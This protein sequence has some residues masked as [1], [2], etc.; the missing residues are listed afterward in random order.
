MSGRLVVIGSLMMDLVV[1]TPR[2]PQNGESIIGTSFGR[3]PGGKGANQASAAGKLGG[4][5]V[6]TGKVGSD[7]FASEMVGAV[8]ECGVDTRY[9]K[10][11][12]TKPSGVASITVEENGSNRIVVVPGANLA[13]DMQ[14]LEDVRSLVESAD[15]LLMQLEM[16][17]KMT[18][19]AVA[20]ANQAGVPVILNPAPAQPL[21]DSLL[22]Q[23]TYLTP[24]E[25]EAS[26]LTD[27]EVTDLVSA[28]QAAD[29]LLAKGVNNVCITLGENGVCLVNK[30]QRVHIPGHSV[31]AV[32]TVAAGDAFNGAFACALLEG[33]T[34]E[35]ALRFANA[36]GALAVTKQ[37]AIPSIPT[38][39]EVLALLK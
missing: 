25:T 1:R 24:N 15:M 4:N 34:A 20:M 27:V 2:A 8:K 29:V 3:F 18:E 38:R 14:D 5:V 16:D 13:F 9:V 23:V 37:G 7:P 26:L 35:D 19:A 28:Y 22:K 21:P 10:V 36:A 30:E 12:D 33:K 17:L 39:D 31:K 6:M 32:D 11:D